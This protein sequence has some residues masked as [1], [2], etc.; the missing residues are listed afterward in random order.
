MPQIDEITSHVRTPLGKAPSSCPSPR[1]AGDARRKDAV[2]SDCVRLVIS[3]HRFNTLAGQLGL[4]AAQLSGHLEGGVCVSEKLLK[5]GQG[6]SVPTC[7]WN[8]CPAVAVTHLGTQQ[9]R[10][11]T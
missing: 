11:Q 2:S 4:R 5:P 1:N 7:G 3:Q 8:S 6:Q 10:G 9:L